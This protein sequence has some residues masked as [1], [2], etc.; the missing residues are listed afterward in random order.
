M[1]IPV[2]K[3]RAYEDISAQ[4][5]KQILDGSWKEGDRIQGELELAQLFQ[6]SRGS[7]REAIKSL[8]MMGVLEAQSGHGTF[9]SQNAIQKIGDNRLIEMIN[10]NEYRDQV[11]ECRY[12]IE[13]QAAFVAAQV[14]TDQDISYLRY[15]YEKMMEYSNQGNLKE[16]NRYGQLF[17]SYIVGMMKNEILSAIYKSI[18]Q[19]LLD[20]RGAFAESNETNVLLSFHEEHLDLINALQVHDAVHARKIMD[21]HLGRQVHWKRLKQ[22]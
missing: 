22:R 18:E 11:L 21:Q 19:Q 16:M 8:Q 9:V 13:P 6:V 1:L 14:C 4:I 20:E 5:Q 2:K 15:T 17:H 12:I 10:D 3:K 7:I